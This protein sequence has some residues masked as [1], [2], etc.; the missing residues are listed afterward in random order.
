MTSLS[1]ANFSSFNPS[2]FDFNSGFGDGST[3]PVLD[4]PIFG[5][6][7]AIASNQG[8]NVGNY[9][10][11]AAN[12]LGGM[13]GGVGSTVGGAMNFG[14]LFNSA[15]EV[16]DFANEQSDMTAEQTRS[17]LNDITYGV[18]GQTPAEEY[19]GLLNYPNT[20]YDEGILR[21]YG[22][23]PR[24]G[25]MQANPGTAAAYDFDYAQQVKDMRGVI[26]GFSPLYREDVM[27]LSKDPPT[28]TID[29]STY[30]DQI[31]KYLDAANLS[32]TYDYSSPQTQGFLDP[33]PAR[34]RRDAMKRDYGSEETRKQFMDYSAY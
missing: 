16:A 23:T 1:G 12:I 5:N 25:G 24:Y 27:N 33:A 21:S 34:Y 10:N 11:L 29:P 4:A 19:A 32:K 26:E 3:F 14:D 17:I 2:A 20:F 22:A 6:N 15:Q 8:N 7:S 31:N 18:T 30:D 28:V 9:L 13:G